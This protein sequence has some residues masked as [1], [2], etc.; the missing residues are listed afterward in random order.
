MDQRTLTALEFDKVLGRLER[1]CAFSV[2]AELA[3]ALQ[4]S[5]DWQLVD[6]AQRRTTEATELLTTAPDFAVRGARDIRTIVKQARVGA[7]LVAPQL[8]EVRDTAGAAARLHASFER[9]SDAGTRFPEL[10]DLLLAVGQFPALDAAI[11]RSIGP[12]GEVLDTA[13]PN[14]GRIRQSIRTA[15]DR[16][17]ER[18]NGLLQSGKYGSAIREPIVTMREGRYVIPVRADARGTVGGV[19]HDSSASGLTVFVEPLETI[20]AQNRWRQLQLDEEHEVERILRALSSL[21]AAEADGL[22]RTV[23]ALADVELQLAKGRYGRELDATRPVIHGASDVGSI[24]SSGRAP[25]RIALTQ[26]R[27]PLLPG[28]VVP[29]A[30]TLGDG[31]RVLVITGPNTGGKTVALKTV[32]LLVLMAQA[33]L[34]IPAAPGSVL[35]VF[36]RVFADIGDEQSIEQSLSTFSSHMLAIVGA[37]AH[38]SAGSLVLLDEVGAGTDP[39]EGSALARAILT[40]LLERGALAI[41]TTHYAAMK[42][43]A[44]ATEGVENASV[45]FDVATLSPTYRLITGIPGRSYGLAIAARLGLADEIVARAR[46]YLSGDEAHVDEL[47]TAIQ[48]E[49]ELAAEE[50]LRAGQAR[51]GAEQLRREADA[52]LAEA[53]RRTAAAREEAFVAMEAELAEL[54]DAVRQLGREREQ[55][56]VSRDW[57]RGAGIRADELREELRR[58]RAARAPR[59]PVR[60]PGDTPRPGDRVE[61]ASLGQQAEVVAIL[62]GGEAE[63]QLGTFRLRRP[64]AELRR[65]GRKEAGTAGSR[66]RRDGG[67]AA[68]LD[69]AAVPLDIDLRGLRA[70]ETEDTLERYLNEAYL[71]SLPYVRIIH[72][73]G[74][75]ALRQSVREY[76]RQ[77]P[78]VAGFES[79][80]DRQGGEGVTIVKLRDT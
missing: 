7:L 49:R 64:L 69:S 80:A 31:Y 14:L 50:R 2:A 38:L 53:A 26:A 9:L 41:A 51:L 59:S 60:D 24:T 17:L 65:I 8:L 29:I 40:I 70:L 16:L 39:S 75:G 46:G 55:V 67:A 19:V 34:H 66:A 25:G 21:V 62:D 79:E 13:S 42:T 20:E 44:Y 1:H 63:L 28:P 11:A 52:E 3:R 30:V 10:G 15:H 77:H 12:R 6:L 73:K 23:A 47:L 74:T 72:G 5:P 36:E 48:A 57:V 22:E 61:V 4:P 71:A 54:R 56:A 78:L 58:A 18:L 37:I 45:E 27:H 35:S 43:F 76:V 32:G 33:G 68:R